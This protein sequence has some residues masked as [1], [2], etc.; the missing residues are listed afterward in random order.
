MPKLSDDKKA[1]RRRHIIVAA[2]DC[3][4][5][6]G[7]DGT[8][9]RDICAES[10]VSRG[11]LYVYFENKDELI[12]AVFQFLSEQG[13]TLFADMPPDD[14]GAGPLREVMRRAFMMFRDPGVMKLLAIDAELKAYCLR[15]PRLLEQRKVEGGLVVS[16]V[17][18][19]VVQA[20]ERGLIEEDL[21]PLWVAAMMVAVQDGTKQTMTLYGDELDVDRYLDVIMRMFRISE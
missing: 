16:A 4:A 19:F 15:N 5:A 11:G 20:Q 17:R 1:E 6:K 8:S 18:S 2:L 14:G 7:V 10:G 9:M 3:F 13:Q 12:E 21:D